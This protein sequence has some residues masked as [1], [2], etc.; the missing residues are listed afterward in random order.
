[1]SATT[2]GIRTAAKDTGHPEPEILTI[3][4]DVSIPE[5]VDA[6]AEKVQNSFGYLDIVINN[7]VFMK[8]VPIA[9]SDPA[10][11]LQALTAGVFGPSL[12]AKAMAP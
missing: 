1:M 3:K 6:L 11:W 8:M 9:E 4:T 5:G 12:I 2:E 10:D 7:A